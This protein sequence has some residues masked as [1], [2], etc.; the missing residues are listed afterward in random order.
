MGSGLLLAL[1]ILGLI[2]GWE[3]LRF[4]VVRRAR[5]WIHAGA[6]RFVRQHRIRLESA[7]FIDRV[8]IREA[9]AQDPTIEQKVAEIAAKT[10]TAP[11][12]LR[13]RVDRYVE[14]I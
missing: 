2:A 11:V 12:L 5:G 14:E 10:G 4:L 8:W 6:V 13:D 9:L 7:R 3:I 1:K